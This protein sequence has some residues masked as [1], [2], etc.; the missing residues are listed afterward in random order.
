M[1][2]QPPGH[3]LAQINVAKS[4]FDQ[5]DRRFAGFTGKI[6]AVNAVAER[7]PGFIWRLKS[8][9]GNAMDIQATDDP[10]FLINMSVWESAEA[11]EDFVWKTIHV[12][13]Y[14]QK[15]EWF[16]TLETPH[17]AFWWVPVG[18]EPS[19]SEGMS[20]LDSLRL[21]GPTSEA[22]G[23]ESLPHVAQWRARRCG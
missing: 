2:D 13:V 4:R 17:M 18:H 19:V 22:F 23:W 6:D 15:A 1:F 21:H 14:D 7:A 5:D 11:L 8:D 3:H 20:K 10:R 16:P 12:K 9:A